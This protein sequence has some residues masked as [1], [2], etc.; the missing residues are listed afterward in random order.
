MS[1]L[2]TDKPNPVMGP[3]YS[4]IK[5]GQFILNGVVYSADYKHVGTAPLK[6]YASL[7]ERDQT[8]RQHNNLEK[9]YELKAVFDAD[10]KTGTHQMAEYLKG[11]YSVKTIHG[12][13]MR[14]IFI[15]KDGVYI[16]G[17]ETL[18][19]E[20]REILIESCNIHYSK[21]IIE[22]IKDCTGANRKEFSVDPNLINLQ[23]GVLDIKSGVLIP[24]DPQYVF[25]NRFPVI[26][27]KEAECP[28]IKKY[29]SEVLDENQIPIIQEWLGYALHRDY[30]I[31][32]AMVFLGEGDTGKTTL[33]SL[34]SS[35][36]GENNIS[37]VSLQS[38]T[39]DKFA[40]A[41]LYGKHINLIDDL[42]AKDVNDNGAFKMATGA[43]FITGEKKFG[44][45]FQFK[46]YAKLTFACNKIPDVKDTND[47]AYFN[48]WIVM[49]FDKVIEKEN[50]DKRL[51]HKIT[52]AE[53]L[54]GLLNF[55]LEGLRRLIEKEK[56]SYEKDALEIKTE[57]LRSASSTAQ[58]AYECLEEATMD[59]W[60]SK[61]NMYQ[62]FLKYAH[63]SKISPAGMK[64][65]GSKLPL[66]ARYIAEGRPVDQKSKLQVTAWRNV[67]LKDG[68]LLDEG[69]PPEK[70]VQQALI[71]S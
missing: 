13:K 18:K 9:N 14:E 50:Q 4:K 25:F 2:P 30:F 16:A 59:E 67:K 28:A 40:C 55:T 60:T 37:G 23:N 46:N 38:L 61:E 47:D 24:H 27:Q 58:F 52:T 48:R 65:F 56:F 34:C 21:E 11:I 63:I 29:L 6:E 69:K 66:Y 33:I 31:K 70:P 17:E 32:K 19:K 15:Y 43:G 5:Q 26:Y 20:I 39:S 51:I 41:H 54:S 42:S 10:K 57:M 3:D 1:E 53:E 71:S 44:D 45:Q 49:R 68:H 7:D 36:F 8:I 22:A 62:A 64:T 35:F 12:T